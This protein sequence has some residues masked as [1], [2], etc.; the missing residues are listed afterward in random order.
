MLGRL[1]YSRLTHGKPLFGECMGFL[2]VHGELP[3][4]PFA[5]LYI[6]N[7]RVGTLVTAYEFIN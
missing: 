1:G 3:V 2:R 6:N 4:G 7:S 5:V